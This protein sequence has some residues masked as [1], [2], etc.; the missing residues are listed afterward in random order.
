VRFLADE[1][2]DFSVVRAP[3]AAGYDVAAAAEWASGTPDG[4]VIEFARAQRRVLLTGDKDFG[5]LV[6]SA[7]AGSGGVI[8]IRYPTAARQQLPSSVVRLT[9]KLGARLET[10]FVTIS[11]GRIRV[12]RL[13]S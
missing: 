3:R 12:S 7:L 13:P 6:F 1:S 5:Q 8:L 10:V 11:P 4:K 2:C 9:E